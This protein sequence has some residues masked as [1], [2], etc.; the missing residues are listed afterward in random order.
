MSTDGNKV[1]PGKKR[2]TAGSDGMI[3]DSKVVSLGRDV[4]A[5]IGQHLRTMYD[6]VVKQGVPD[7]FNELL[8]KLDNTDEPE[9]SR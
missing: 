5:K 8:R 2:R 7:H 1:R 9:K 6:E 4:Q 3:V